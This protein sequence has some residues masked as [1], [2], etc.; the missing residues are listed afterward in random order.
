MK[1]V[2]IVKI[3]LFVS[4]IHFL[5]TFIVFMDI[6]QKMERI[7]KTFEVYLPSLDEIKDKVKGSPYVLTAVAVAAALVAAHYM[8]WNYRERAH[9]R[10]MD[11]FKNITEEL[12]IL[13]QY[14][15]EL[16]SAGVTDMEQ[17]EEMMECRLKQLRQ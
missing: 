1:I 13:M 16:Y 8:Y 14:Q 4:Q 2:K 17:M 7:I 15:K 5:R 6:W 11:I 12:K 3:L 10:K 9:R